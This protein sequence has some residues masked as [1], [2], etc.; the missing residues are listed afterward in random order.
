MEGTEV[1][2]LKFKAGCDKCCN[3][4]RQ[5][6]GNPK[7]GIERASWSLDDTLTSLEGKENVFVSGVGQEHCRWGKKILRSLE[8]EKLLVRKMVK[9][10]T[11]SWCCGLR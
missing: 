2:S 1:Y 6:N 10:S 11:S 4:S 5:G 8:V 3:R 7:E 9:G